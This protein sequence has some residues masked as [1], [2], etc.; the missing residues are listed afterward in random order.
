M[1]ECM[2]RLQR[3]FLKSLQTV[4]K[5]S[6]SQHC[7]LLCPS[8]QIAQEASL[9]R[10]FKAFHWVSANEYVHPLLAVTLTH[11]PT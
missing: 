8:L 9:F 11:P 2:A 4:T 6:G 10:L 3:A 5:P 7:P 1:L